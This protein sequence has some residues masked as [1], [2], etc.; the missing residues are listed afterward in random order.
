MKMAIEFT[1]NQRLAID[2]DAGP[3]LVAAA[4][5][6]GK[7]AVLVERAVRIICDEQKKT[8][9]DRLLIVTFT[10]AA[11]NE[12]S[13][14]I[15]ARL[16]QAVRE[17]PDNGYIKEQ[18]ML[19]P[20]AS[21]TTIDSFCGNLAR[22]YFFE[23]GISASYKIAEP[24][25]IAVMQRTAMDK[26][27]EKMYENK[28]FPKLCDAL[29]QS[30]DDYG[31]REAVKELYTHARSLAFPD[32]WMKKSIE[33]YTYD[34]LSDNIFVHILVENAIEELH[35]IAGYADSALEIIPNDEAHGK[36]KEIFTN[37]ADFSKNT[38][39]AL[40]KG[41]I[42]AACTLIA[43]YDCPDF[44]RSKKGYDPEVLLE[45]KHLGGEITHSY[46]K[47]CKLLPCGEKEIAN[48]LSEQKELAELLFEVLTLYSENLR[49][50]KS[51]KELYEFNDI[52]HFVLELI[53]KNEN[54]KIAVTDI[55]KNIS[56]KFDYVM[57][58]E[59]QDTNSLQDTVFRVLSDGGKNL[60]IVGDSKQSIYRFRQANPDI[61]VKSQEQSKL[62]DDSDGGKILLSENFRSRREVCDTVN[63]IFGA[64]MSREAG[65]I[66]YD[67]EH[68]LV[69]GANYPQKDGMT[70]ELL[71]IDGSPSLDKNEDAESFELLDDDRAEAAIIA[72]KI[73]S[74][75]QNGEI[76]DA[77]S[78]CCRKPKYGDFAI[79]L[80][81]V[82]G[83]A[84]KYCDEL[85]KRGIPAWCQKKITFYERPEI[86]TV[87][88][89]LKAADNPG[90]N[91]A[92]LGFALGPLGGLDADQTA[93]IR[94]YKSKGSLYSAFLLAA[95]DGNA[96]AVRILS[97]L[98]DIREKAMS[99]SLPLLIDYIYGFS[100]YYAVCSAAKDGDDR[101]ANLRKLLSVAE[102]Y[103]KNSTGGLSGFV[104]YVEDAA[105]NKTE[106]KTANIA[107]EGMVPVMT[108]HA[109]KGLEYPVVFL[110]RCGSDFK[111]DNKNV[112][113]SEKYGVGICRIDGDGLRR[114]TVAQRAIQTVNRRETVAENMRLLYVALTRASEKLYM[115][116]SVKD[117]EKKR[118]EILHFYEATCDIMKRDGL[119][120]SFIHGTKSFADWIFGVLN[121]NRTFT[122]D[123]I[124]EG[125]GTIK[126]SIVKKDT[127]SAEAEESVSETRLEADKD[128]SRKIADR[129]SHHRKTAL[130]NISAKVTASEL[131]KADHGGEYDFT[132]VPEFL[133]GAAK[134]GTDYGTA[135]HTFMQYCDFV[136]AADNLEAEIARL[137]DIG[138]LEKAAADAISRKS[139]EKFFESDLCRRINS[140]DRVLRE[141]PFTVLSSPDRYFADITEEQ[142]DGRQIVLQGVCDLVFRE[143]GSPVVVDYKT[144]RA[145][146]AQQLRE[147]YSSQLML[148]ADAVSEITGKPTAAVIIYSF[149]CGEYSE[150]KLK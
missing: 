42:D 130:S 25:D 123:G 84:D 52:E 147:K 10:R 119:S 19:L 133:Q 72:E 50:L 80:R 146:S 9:C 126:V 82:S 4:A 118:L 66:N 13:R 35:L 8:P 96:D 124:T 139:L 59:Y 60:F 141:P 129:I 90:R 74:I 105:E 28:L 135:V 36:F 45:A 39:A 87:L 24:G 27:V 44:G 88:S 68:M 76:Y 127:L 85:E 106:I 108:I 131:N 5:G 41:D 107:P 115:V 62:Y 95:K 51:E 110:A 122:F 101:C 1:E 142:A 15:T 113:I 33:N 78:G 23:L 49:Q 114:R 111:F 103:E 83:H 70:S 7:T 136:S 71:V 63:E 20:S 92:L 104:R 54:G 99:L 2:S 30:Y 100:G 17:N 81:A 34:S 21:I 14:R 64:A 94:L 61:F 86:L 89:L 43:F 65:E 12:M 143:N 79:L 148:Y 150:Y 77:K 132:A 40:K 3:V 55:G 149:Y 125:R 73:K 140:S 31:L 11:A 38:V 6:S 29:F 46:G 37:A 67:G 16:E 58:D 109:S 98:S 57:V 128:I 48:E 53:C 18:L 137:T 102:S 116:A 32:E 120:A 117:F 91:T 144:D 47:I 138:K 93:R 22:E 134:S 121:I 26:T 145:Q 56:Q 69:V 75:M 112:E 97:I